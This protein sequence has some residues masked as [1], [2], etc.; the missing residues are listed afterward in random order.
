MKNLNRFNLILSIICF[1]TLPKLNY[2]QIS[3]TNPDLEAPGCASCI[4][5][6]PTDWFICAATSPDTQPGEFGV[7]TPPKSGCTYV[8]M[9]HQEYI[10]QQLACPFIANKTY[11]LTVWLAF[12][13]YYGNAWGPPGQLDV[14]GGTSG[15]TMTEL[16]WSSG[17]LPVGANQN[18][19]EYTISFT[20]TATYD[21][22]TFQNPFP[23][24]NILIDN[25]SQTIATV[26][27]TLNIAKGT[28]D[29][30]NDTDGEATVSVTGTYTYN[31][32]WS[33]GQLDVGVTSSTN[34]NLPVGNNT[35][36][37]IDPLD[38]C[39]APTVVDVIINAP[40]DIELDIVKVDESCLDSKDGTA[41]VNIVSGGVAPFTYL[42]DDVAAS[43]TANIASL[44]EGY[45]TVIVTD[46]NNLSLIHI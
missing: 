22:I 27:P 19:I 18:W 32:Q 44:S 13:P 20:P 31:F 43:T 21:F 8:G 28:L 6:T 14:Y 2:A 38:Q 11:A 4:A 35:V 3:I 1:F 46:A 5:C 45:Y 7:F 23:M 15:C 37:I 42:W 39:V 10:S 34:V 33:N 41:Q 40:A 24:T 9:V 29:C 17:V 12:N 30:G 36:T 25:I 26:V 16:F